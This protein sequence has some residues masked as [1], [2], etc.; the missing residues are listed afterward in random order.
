M[1]KACQGSAG[2]MLLTNAHTWGELGV[3]VGAGMGKLGK[4]F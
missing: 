2:K 1:A 4:R 3:P